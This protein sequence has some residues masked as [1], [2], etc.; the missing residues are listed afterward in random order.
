M[1]FIDELIEHGTNFQVR[2]GK[3]SVSFTP[4]SGRDEDIEAFQGVVRELH[5]NEGD[6][7]AV[8]LSHKLSDQTAQLIDLV[9]VTL[10]ASTFRPD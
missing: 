4:V 3:G 6:G 2:R 10:H 5:R 1:N 8:H 7:Y 9:I